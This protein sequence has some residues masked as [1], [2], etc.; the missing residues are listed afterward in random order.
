MSLDTGK[1]KLYIKV[2]CLQWGISG[3]YLR[4]S[5]VVS[6]TLWQKD[7]TTNLLNLLIPGRPKETGMDQGPRISSMIHSYWP[8]FFS[9]A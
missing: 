3:H 1:V 9:T 7:G 6:K 5:K 2:P 8:N 4:R